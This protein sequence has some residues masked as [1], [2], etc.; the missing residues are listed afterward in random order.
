MSEPSATTKE[1]SLTPVR[2]EHT[3]S[4]LEVLERLGACLLV[5]T[6]QAG[7]LLVLAAHEGVLSCSFHGFEQVMGIAVGPS[8]IAVGTRRQIWFLRSTPE[9]APRVK[10]AG[11][12]D[13]CYLTRSSHVTGE[14]HAHEMAWVGDELWFVNTLFSCLCTL[15]DQFSFVPRWKPKF[16]TALAGDDRC[17]LNGLAMEDGRARYLT[18]H[19]SSDAAGGWRP[20]KATG[21]CLIDA[22]SGEVAARGFAMPHSPRIRDGKLWLLNSGHGRISTVDPGTGREEPVAQL[23]GYTR[24]LTFIGP[25]AFIGLSKIRERSVFGGLPIEQRRA[26]LHCGIRVLDTRTGQIVAGLDFHSG[27]EEIFAVESLPGV[28]AAAL[29]GPNPG[30]DGNEIIWYAPNLPA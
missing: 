8:K 10:P 11:K 16:I 9:L 1:P 30:A 23:P 5:S 27:V 21:G 24:G 19:G 14:V 29:T 25:Y 20:D 28:R 13:A 12:H 22:D 4:F 2:F 15:G 26:D 3:L 6:Y 18:A 7:K 17:H